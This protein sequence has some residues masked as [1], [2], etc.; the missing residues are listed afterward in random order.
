MVAGGNLAQSRDEDRRRKNPEDYE[1]MVSVESST[2]RAAGRAASG[3]WHG[4][5]DSV[6]GSGLAADLLAAGCG[7]RGRRV[8]LAR[9]R[10]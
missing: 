2:V 8:P 5:I 4:T 1:R 3:R 10:G 9:H 7:G 6:V